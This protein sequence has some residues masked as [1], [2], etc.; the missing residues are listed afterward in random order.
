MSVLGNLS[1]AIL[2]FVVAHQYSGLFLLLVVEEAGVPL[3]LPGDTLIM[4]LG[5]RA[6]AG[7][8]NAVLTI[9]IVS[10]AATIGSSALYWLARRGG[11][12]ALRRY[13]RFLHLHP[14]RVD[15][16]QAR[17]QRWGVWAIIVGR[18]IPGLR[19]P[20]S[21]MAGLFDVPYR[22]FAPSTAVSALLWALFY[23]YFGALLAPQWRAALA[24]VTGD[25]DAAVGVGLVAVV[26]ALAVAVLLRRRRSGRRPAPI[27]YSTK[28]N[29]RE[30][31][32]A[33]LDR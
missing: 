17:F 11:R 13:G 20:T 27:K 8:A 12:P 28:Y 18:L 32:D 2:A 3:P 10:A 23:F 24:A 15:R 16:M 14:E 4:Y 31:A 6:M 9:A 33:H 5:V 30:G 21:V 29:A 19:T 1:R 26:A 22:V 7:Q 25:L